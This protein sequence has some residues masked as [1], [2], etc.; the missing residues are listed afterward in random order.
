MKAPV[1]LFVPAP[2]HIRLTNE[3]VDGI[4]GLNRDAPVVSAARSFLVSTLRPHLEGV[5]DLH[6][7]GGLHS[8]NLLVMRAKEAAKVHKTTEEREQLSKGDEKLIEE[9]VEQAFAHVRKLSVHV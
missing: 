8:R 4:V 6:Q 9:T 3:A 7:P 1:S 2:S 5:R